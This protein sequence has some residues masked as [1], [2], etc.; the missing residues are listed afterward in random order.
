MPAPVESAPGA[1]IWGGRFSALVPMLQADDLDVT[2]EWYHRV[3]GFEVSRRNEDWCRLTRDDV[4]LM[5][6]RNAHLGPPRATATQYLYVAD[7]M[8]L[9]AHVGKFC[10]AEWGPQVMPYGLLEFAVRD[11]NGYLLSFGQPAPQR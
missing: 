2:A 9:W 11:P 10:K 5:F 3:L 6:M 1:G 7:V 4:A 8:G